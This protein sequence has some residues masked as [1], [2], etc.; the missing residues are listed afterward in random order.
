MGPSPFS[1]GVVLSLAKMNRILTI[2]LDN[3]IAVVKPGVITG[4][5]KKADQSKGLFYPPD[6]ASVDTCSIGGNAAT[7]R[8]GHPASNTGQRATTFWVWR[9]CGPRES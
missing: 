6:P 8:G 3:L 4:D 5:L 9:W 2:D 1:G 7:K